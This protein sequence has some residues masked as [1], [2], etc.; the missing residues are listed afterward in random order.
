MAMTVEG[1][2]Q[3]HSDTQGYKWDRIYAPDE[4]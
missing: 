2:W 1:M 4:H 3:A